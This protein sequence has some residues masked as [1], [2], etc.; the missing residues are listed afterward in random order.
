MSSNRKRNTP[1][2]AVVSIGCSR[3]KSYLSLRRAIPGPKPAPFPEP[4][5]RNKAVEPPRQEPALNSTPAIMIPPSSFSDSE[6][7]AQAYW[8]RVTQLEQ[9][10]QKLDKWLSTERRLTECIKGG[11]REEHRKPLLRLADGSYLHEIKRL[12]RPWGRLVMQISPPTIAENASTASE[13]IR[14]MMSMKMEDLCKCL[15][16]SM[17][18]RDITGQ[19]RDEITGKPVLQG[20]EDGFMEAILLAAMEKMEGLVLEGLRIQMGSSR[21]GNN[22]IE[23]RGREKETTDDCVVVVVLIQVRDPKE[24]FGATGELMIGIIEASAADM[25]GTRFNIRGVHVAGLSFTRKRI[26]GKDFLWSA[27][28]QGCRGSHTSCCWQYVR[29]PDRVFA[30]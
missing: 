1:S 26:D 5:L 24:D 20:S 16:E 25:E 6:A 19:R 4:S 7:A 13:V 3:I 17:P 23:K 27:S 22:G 8:R 9:E 21:Q 10:L 15:M 18:M 11:T 28:L 12:G 30:H 2:S 29:N 14:G